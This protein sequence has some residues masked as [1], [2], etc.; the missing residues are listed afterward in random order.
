MVEIATVLSASGFG[1]MVDALGL[2]ACVSVRCRVQCG[3]GRRPCRHHVAMDQP[4][5]ERL[6][7]V[8]ERLGPTFVKAGQILALRPDYVPLPYADALGSLH[9]AAQPFPGAQA[10]AIV[11]AELGVPLHELFASF[12]L[13]PF[14]AAS[15][16]PV[17]RATLPDGG[18]VAVK[19]Q[20]PRIER[21][22]EQ[23]LALLDRLARR[24]ERRR[25]DTLAFRPR[26][27]VAELADYTR[28]ELDFRREAAVAGRVRARFADHPQVVVPEVDRGR[29]SRRVLTMEYV[30][31]HRPAPAAQLRAAGL[32][33]PRLLQIGAEA[34]LRQIFAHG[35]F[36]A[37]PHP[38]NLLFADGD[39]VCFLDFG[40]HGRLSLR[41]RR[42]MGFLLWALLDGDHDT[43]ADQLLR[44]S[45]PRP[46]ADADGFRD[47]LA[48]V[49]EEWQTSA[50]TAGYTTA[51]LLLRQL[52]VGG[53]HGIVFPPEL[54]LLAR[55]LVTTEATAAVI[56]PAASLVELAAPLL[57]ELRRLLLLDPDQL[58]QRWHT[59]RFDLLELT[60]D[61]PDLVA[62][63][64]RRS[65]AAGPLT[66]TDASPPKLSRLGRWGRWGAVSLAASTL[67][68]VGLRRRR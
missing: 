20:R 46:G 37:D 53:Q 60:L 55:A 49:V 10:Q 34:M 38:G 4:L 33:P 13:A 35:V 66:G 36:H 6:R 43:V 12:E 25:P 42:R 48:E 23:D 3:I 63:L 67:V 62:E 14:A 19:V 44:L 39:R 5:P 65:P 28:R 58:R 47:A 31:G 41:Q 1:W 24:L 68:A 57:P 54:M 21:Q 52:A 18:V 40:L 7:L 32:D 61:L 2:N 27:A 59:R 45:S 56:D 26:A 29:S 51:R 9:D 64:A 50:P 17:H 15:L 8:L 16:S 22:I 11:E 30:D